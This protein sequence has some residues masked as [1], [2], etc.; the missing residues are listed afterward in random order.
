MDVARGEAGL[1]AVLGCNSILDI[2]SLDV[3]NSSVWC[4]VRWNQIRAKRSLL[5]DD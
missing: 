1:I 4:E 2:G 3:N 5:E